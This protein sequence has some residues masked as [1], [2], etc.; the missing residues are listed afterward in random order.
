MIQ[1]TMPRTVEGPGRCIEPCMVGQALDGM[2]IGLIT[3]TETGHVSWANRAGLRVLGL[4]RSACQGK[5]LTQL[6]RDPQF[7]AFWSEAQ[8]KDDGAMGEVRIHWPHEACLKVTVTNCYDHGGNRM[9]RAIVFCDVTAERDLQVRMSAEAT[10][11][12]LRMAET[13]SSSTEVEVKGGLTGQE[14][15]VLR[16][17]GEGLGNQ[18]IA[19]RLFVAPSTIRSHLK[20]IYRKTGLHTRAEAVRY[21]V[22]NGLASS[23]A[24]PMC[25]S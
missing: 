1:K 22:G 21:A 19:R 10:E 16:L 9:G 24:S 4:Q 18:E 14:L 3:L 5:A 25:Q 7:M 8:D 13:A 23:L 6:L 17:V 15:K 20:Q 11:R 12:L 2:C